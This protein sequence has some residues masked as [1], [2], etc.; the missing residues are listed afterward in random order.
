MTD[1]VILAGGKGSRLKGIVP[2]YFKPML[3]VDGQALIVSAI[4]AAHAAEVG[5]IIIVLAPENAQAMLSLLRDAEALDDDTYFVIQHTANGPGD[6]Y[7]LAWNFVTTDQVLLLMADNVFGLTDVRNVVGELGDV[8]VGT[9]AIEDEETAAHFTRVTRG[10]SYEGP[11]VT[12]SQRWHVGEPYQCWLGPLKVN[13][14]DL[15]DVLSDNR[16][17]QE[18]LKIGPY[19]GDVGEIVSVPCNTHDVGDASHWSNGVERG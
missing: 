6:A 10:R 19:L 17:V 11:N 1:C 2:Q 14:Q 15:Y 8:V 4:K 16:G 18:E 5:R 9:K 3:V 7:M 12:N 13:A